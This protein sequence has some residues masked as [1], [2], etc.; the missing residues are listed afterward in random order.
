MIGVIYDVSYVQI[1]TQLTIKKILLGSVPNQLHLN[2]T[3]V[4]DHQALCETDTIHEMLM[5][6]YTILALLKH[7]AI[8]VIAGVQSTLCQGGRAFIIFRQYSM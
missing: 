6:I 5:R 3:E 1:L 7:L 8:D 2:D 4:Y